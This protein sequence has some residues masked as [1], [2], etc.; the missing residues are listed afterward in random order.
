MGKNKSNKISRKKAMYLESL[1]PVKYNDS[2]IIDT[3][4]EVKIVSKDGN[5]VF[6]AIKTKRLDV[7]DIKQ[8]WLLSYRAI[9]GS[10]GRGFLDI[11][12]VRETNNIVLGDDNNGIITIPPRVASKKQVLN[13]LFKLEKTFDLTHWKN[14]KF[15]DL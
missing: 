9:D 2:N 13:I 1:K 3:S 15:I 10:F 12:N 11:Q 4:K 6:H 7:M 5:Y 14:I 8:Y